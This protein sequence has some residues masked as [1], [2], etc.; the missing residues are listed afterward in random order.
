MAQ[1]ERPRPHGTAKKGGHRKG[2]VR[3]D[4]PWPIP[5]CE[6]RGNEFSP[7]RVVRES[8]WMASSADD[9]PFGYVLELSHV[10]LVWQ[11]QCS[12]TNG[13]GEESGEFR[14]EKSKHAGN[15]QTRKTPAKQGEFSLILGS[16][17]GMTLR[18]ALVSPRCR[19]PTP[20]P[21]P[22]GNGRLQT[23]GMNV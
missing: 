10:S 4:H 14:K 15:S 1:G 22:S 3:D 12:V 9:I 16:R 6:K 7:T 20:C 18:N 2:E 13:K 19:N 5:N 11:Y 23:V 17:A 8:H 21:Q